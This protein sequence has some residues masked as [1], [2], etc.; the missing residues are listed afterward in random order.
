ME[1]SEFAPCRPHLRCRLLT[2]AH[3]IGEFAVRGSDSSSSSSSCNVVR[4]NDPTVRPRTSP[5]TH[6]ESRACK[7]GPISRDQ[8]YVRYDTRAK[9]GAFPQDRDR[10]ALFYSTVKQIRFGI[11]RRYLQH[12]ILLPLHPIKLH[13]VVQ[14]DRSPVNEE[15]R[16]WCS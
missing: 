10:F 6:L 5:C 7:S 1:P 13:P 15:Q 8:P 14:T 2:H 3:C 12:H 16:W 11:I 4:A 9:L